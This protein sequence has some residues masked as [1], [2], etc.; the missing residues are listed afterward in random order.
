MPGWHFP[1]EAR[2]ARDKNK[3]DTIDFAA[4]A[5][6]DDAGPFLERCSMSRDRISRLRFVLLLAVVFITS[7]G[8]ARPVVPVAASTSLSGIDAYI[9]SVMTEWKVPGLAIA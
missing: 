3:R 2:R 1:C 6:S 7:L 8:A 9:E 5:S 4:R